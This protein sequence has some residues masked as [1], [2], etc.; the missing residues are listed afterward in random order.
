MLYDHRVLCRDYDSVDAIN[1]VD[2]G[3]KHTYMVLKL[4]SCFRR[5]GLL[6]PL[7]V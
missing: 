2:S 5:R 4:P 7:L 6:A 3:G 1:S